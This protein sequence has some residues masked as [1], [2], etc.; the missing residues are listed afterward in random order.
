MLIL[1]LLLISCLQSQEKAATKTVNTGFTQQENVSVVEQMD[2]PISDGEK[3]V[4]DQIIS[5]RREGTT[6]AR[7]GEKMNPSH[8]AEDAHREQ[9]SKEETVSESV[10]KPEEIDQQIPVARADHAHWDRLLKNYVSPKGQV[11]YS[12]LKTE[13][14]A[15]DQYLANLAQFPPDDE[16]DRNEVMAYWINAY[17]AFTVKLIL[18]NYPLASI[19]DL[20]NGKVWDRKWIKIGGRAYSLNEIEHDILRKAYRDARIHFAVNCAAKSCP[21]LANKAFTAENLES[22]LNKQASSFINN[23]QFNQ[24]SSSRA[25][26]SK[27]FEWY[28]S[29]FGDIIAYLN[30]YANI[31]LSVGSQVAYNEYNWAL[32]GK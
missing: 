20:D 18:D 24:I 2:T 19:M 3:V 28:A 9:V 29:D 17:N 10:P 13:L 23:S 30:R 4:K 5:V 1:I 8:A 11:D 22:M 26:I 15:L 27:I 21:P 25:S 14:D 31:R 12:G 7:H 6:D 32:N 16:F